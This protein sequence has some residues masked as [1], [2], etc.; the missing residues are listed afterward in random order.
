MKDRPPKV[1]ISYSHDSDAHR[2]NVLALSNRLRDEGLDCHIDQYETSPPEGW[3]DWMLNQLEAAEFV[4]LVCTEIYY[5][6]FRKKEAPGTGK[7]VKWEGAVITLTL[8]DSEVLNQKFIP[9]V[10][11]AADRQYV[12]EILRGTTSYDLT[13]DYEYQRLYRRLT[14]QSIEKP[15]LREIKVLPKLPDDATKTPYLIVKECLPLIEAGDYEGA[16]RKLEIAL[17]REEI[18]HGQQHPNVAFCLN[19][20]GEVH[21]EQEQYRQAREYFER[22]LIIYETNEAANQAEVASCLTNLGA[23]LRKQHDFPRA[24]QAL[25]RSLQILTTKF[26]RQHIEVSSTLNALGN[27]FLD[28]GRFADAQSYYEQAQAI[29]DAL[30]DQNPTDSAVTLNNLGKALHQQGK[31]NEAREQYQQAL[32]ICQEL[33]GEEHPDTLE[34]QRNLDRLPQ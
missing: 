4:L 27:I 24:R 2:S 10:F 28:E 8:Y 34:I 18:R 20:L 1:F 5:R 17:Q 11:A 33:L 15:E 6:R 9:V 19:Y 13:S 31:F 12:P 30:P 22:A 3:P 32:Q 21:Y 25:E 7:G 29:D 16:Q 26:G 14:G 23:V